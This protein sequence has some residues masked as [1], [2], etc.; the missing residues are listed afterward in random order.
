M[1]QLCSGSCAQICNFPV[2]LNII[3]ANIDALMS[4]NMLHLFKK[5]LIYIIIKNAKKQVDFGQD[6]FGQDNFTFFENQLS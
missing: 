1:M 3:E 4:R 2:A 6:N 5:V